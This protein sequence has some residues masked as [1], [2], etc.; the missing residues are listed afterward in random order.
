MIELYHTVAT[1]WH[2]IG[3]FLGIPQGELKIIAERE[4]DPQRCL[5]EMLSVWLCQTNPPPSWP[6]IA[7]AVEFIR[8]PDIAQQIRQ[9]YCK[10]SVASYLLTLWIQASRSEIEVVICSESCF[11][12]D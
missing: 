6:D 12:T 10:C 4:H 8:R 2:T 1:E 5:M 3:T 7:K 9:K 11:W